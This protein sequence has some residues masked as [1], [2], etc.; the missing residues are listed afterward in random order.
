MQQRTV[1]G[2]PRLLPRGAC[3]P[4]PAG[5]ENSN[6]CCSGGRAAAPGDNGSLR[7]LSIYPS[8]QDDAAAAAL[9][10]RK[11]RRSREK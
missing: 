7:R 3:N 10:S 11:E 8:I 5:I 2:G 6:G 4:S 1:C 9:K